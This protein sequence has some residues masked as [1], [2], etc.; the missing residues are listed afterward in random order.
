ME[1]ADLTLFNPI[2]HSYGNGLKPKSK[3]KAGV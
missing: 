2:L 1:A 3:Q